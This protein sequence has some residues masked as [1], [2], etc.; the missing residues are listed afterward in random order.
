MTYLVE[1]LLD[2]DVGAIAI[3]ATPSK[4][5]RPVAIGPEKQRSA[6]KSN[7]TSTNKANIVSEWRQ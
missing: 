4:F 7:D 5:L 1:S 3:D 2:S 6:T